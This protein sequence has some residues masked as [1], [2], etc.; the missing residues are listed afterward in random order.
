M[1][2][3]A[4]ILESLERKLVM[5]YKCNKK[6]IGPNKSPDCK[7]TWLGRKDSPQVSRDEL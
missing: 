5:W 1:L 3:N 6:R 7:R 2:M 4:G